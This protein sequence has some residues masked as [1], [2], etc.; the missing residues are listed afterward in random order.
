MSLLSLFKLEKLTITA[1]ESADRLMPL[2][3]AF[4]ALFN[5]S[6]YSEKL[7]ARWNENEGMNTSVPELDYAGGGTRQISFTLLLDGTYADTLLY[8]RYRRT[9]VATQIDDFRQVAYTYNGDIHEPNYLVVSWGD[10][11]FSCRLASADIKYTLFN[12]DG[13]PLRAELSLTFL[14]DMPAEAVAKEENKR[15][16]DLTH[17]RIVRSGDTLPLLT[18]AIYGSSASYLDVARFNN[19]DDFRNLRPGQQLLFPPLATFNKG[20]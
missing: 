19:L 8:E 10:L 11:D 20:S 18:R 3:D 1:Y 4:E 12:R 9:D 14:E 2:T 16:P 6:S 17:A 15:S 13:T 7:F 5:P